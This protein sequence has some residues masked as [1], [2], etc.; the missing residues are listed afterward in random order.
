MGYAAHAWLYS[1]SLARLE[2]GLV[3]VILFTYPALVTLGAI[4]LGRDRWSTRR[5]IAITTGVAGAALVLVGGFGHIDPTG[6]GLAAAASV[7]YAAYILSSADQL[8]HTDPLSLAALITTSAA[9]TLTVATLGRQDLRLDVGPTA[10][11]TIAGVAVI[12]V[13]GMITLIAG[14]QLLGP[15]RA[16]IVSALQPAV[17]PIVGLAVLADRP[18][19]TQIIG[20]TLI[21]ASVTIINARRRAVEGPLSSLPRRERRQLS[22]AAVPLDVPAGG[23]SSTRAPPPTD[24]SSSSVVTPESH[25]A[26]GPSPTSAPGTASAK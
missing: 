21:V 12:A 1:V 5:A 11:A 9:I 7:A 18:G 25:A 22:R 24:S 17:T 3:D 23:A 10:L 26:I 14:V 6:A 8:E 2:A 4:A 15:S 20:I 19:L 13:A 16:S